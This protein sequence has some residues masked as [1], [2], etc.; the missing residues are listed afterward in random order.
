LYGRLACLWHDAG[1]NIYDKLLL[2][3]LTDIVCSLPMITRNRLKVTPFAEGVV[4]EP[5]IG[6][7]LNL[8]HYDAGAVKQ[9]IGVDPQGDLLKLARERAAGAS[10]P[11]EF[12]EQS[13][14]SLPL[15]D[16]S[17]DTVLLTYTGCSIPDVAAALGEFRRVLKPSGRLL[18]CEHGRSHEHR[19][20]RFQDAANH[21]WQPLAGGCHL[22]RDIEAL[23][24]EA[25]FE[26]EKCD[27]FYAMPRPKFISY[28]YVGSARAR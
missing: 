12:V 22:N 20:A 25:G 24:K 26:V 10:V 4:L 6:S 19:V 11:V 23:L 9:V 2:S 8:A 27:R 15:E 16:N 17:V 1:M 3:P 21:V 5:G 18:F 13:A 7:G 28:H 14:E